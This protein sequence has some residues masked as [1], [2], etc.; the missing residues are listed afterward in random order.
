[1]PSTYVNNLRLEEIATGEQ[2][3]TWGN[4]TNTNLELV[5]Q[6][7]GYG[8]RAIANASTDNITI[9]DGAS[10]ADR[11]MYL[12]LTGGGQAC[13]VTLLPNTSSKMWIMENATSFTLT[14]SQGSGANV[15]VKA[16]QTKMI[17]ADGLGSGAV[18]YELGTVAVQNIQADGTVTVGIDDTGYDVTFFGA[19]TGKKLF[20]D[21]SEDTLNVAGTTALAGNLSVTGVTSNADGA[22]ATPSITNTGDLNTGI[23]FPAADTVGVVTGGVEQFRFGSN[24]IPGK[25]LI[26]NGAMTVAQRGS[27]AAVAS[28]Y[29]AVDR[30]GMNSLSGAPARYTLSQESSGGVGG[31]AKW[32]KILVTTADGSPAGADA[33]YFGQKIEGFDAQALLDDSGDLLASTMSFDIIV[34][35]DGASSLSFPITCAICVNDNGFANQ[36]YVKTFTVAAADTWERGSVAIAANAAAVID[37]DNSNEFQVS[38]TIYAGSAKETTDATWESASGLD[39]SVSGVDNLADATNNYVGIT[40]VQLEVGSVATD[41]EHEDY[42][43]T[44]QKCRRYLRAYLQNANNRKNFVQGHVYNTTRCW[45][46]YIPDTPMRGTIAV[47]YVGTAG[48]IV[49]AYGTGS[50]QATTGTPSVQSAS[51]EGE[52]VEFL[53]DAAS[54]TPFTVGQAVEA[55]VINGSNATAFLFSSEL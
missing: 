32:A 22:V 6:A 26:Q 11:S 29:G 4:T 23:Y 10:D 41:F 13:T 14:F 15:A 33:H 51:T 28:G 44:Y 40:N 12:K 2:S 1:M 30:W 43:T 42:D 48:D 21:E 52:S 45:F 18:V 34:H 27:T 39:V 36:Q 47:S 3:G 31:N 24:P 54:G 17:F 55:Y 8:T 25:N 16:G 49:I 5:G 38:L 7:L 37:N 46:V 53:L 9:A 20:W 35:A 19:T 50:T